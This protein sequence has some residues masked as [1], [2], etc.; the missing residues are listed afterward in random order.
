MIYK[1]KVFIFNNKEITEVFITITLLFKRF[2][3]IYYCN[4]SVSS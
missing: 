3:E 4:L 2:K 1:N